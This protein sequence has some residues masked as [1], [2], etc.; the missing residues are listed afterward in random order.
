MDWDPSSGSV[1]AMNGWY[2]NST[3]GPGLSSPEQRLVT[4]I[5]DYDTFSY[6]ITD[7]LDEYDVKPNVGSDIDTSDA[8][9]FWHNISVNIDVAVQYDPV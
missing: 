1:F 2:T 4:A 7:G 5:S 3:S 9:S 8:P 6:A